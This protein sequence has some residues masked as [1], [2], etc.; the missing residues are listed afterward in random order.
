MRPRT[1]SL[2]RRQSSRWTL[3]LISELLLQQIVGTPQTLRTGASFAVSSSS[4]RDSQCD[5]EGYNH[6]SNQHSNGFWCYKWSLSISL[7]CLFC[8]ESELDDS[9]HLEHKKVCKNIANCI[10]NQLYDNDRWRKVGSRNQKLN[11]CLFSVPVN[12]IPSKT[13][14]APMILSLGISA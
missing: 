1:R 13:L 5:A 9:F 10:S 7:P 12:L 4:Q 11:V 8:S 2:L 14:R 6:A 3:Y